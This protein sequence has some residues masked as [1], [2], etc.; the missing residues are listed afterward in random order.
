MR[1]NLN[2]DTP[3]PPEEPAGQNPPD[4]A[5]VNYW[6]R[7]K[8]AEPVVLEVLDPAGKLVRRFRSDDKPEAPIEGR[9]IP[10][11]W[12]RPPQGLSA[13]PGLHR[14]VWDLHHPVPALPKGSLQ[15]PIAAV[16]G[17]TP[18]APQWPWALP[19]VYTVRL[20]TGGKTQTQALTVKMDPR[21][22]ASTADLQR[23]FDLSQDLVAALDRAD[24]ALRALG[25]KG[26]K[27]VSQ[28][29]GQLAQL[30][31]AV[32]EV[33]AVPTTQVAAAIQ[34]RLAAL[35]LALR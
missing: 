11:F 2:P 8:P 7:V 28:L 18:K 1:F 22:K 3:L 26:P 19:G 20:T 29:Q 24:E 33:D 14:F 17:N 12:I 10:D 13:E 21:V 5:I 35:T 30:Y 32:Q 4:G 16:P 9:N 6:L 31:D 15:Y 34:D 23:Q 27:S 25:D